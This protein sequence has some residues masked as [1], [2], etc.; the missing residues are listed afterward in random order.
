MQ[1]IFWLNT[2]NICSGNCGCSVL[3][4]CWLKF[5]ISSLLLHYWG[6]FRKNGGGYS[7]ARLIRTANAWKN[8]ANYLSMWIIRAYFTLHFYQQQR[9][10]SRASVRIE[11]GMRI[12]EGQIIRAILYIFRGV[13]DW[14]ELLQGEYQVFLLFTHKSLCLSQWPHHTLRNG[15]Y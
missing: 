11:R 5:N 8:C 4:W 14:L 10:V 15:P 12:S 3:H 7:G 9:V 6:K 2:E 13:I 1:A